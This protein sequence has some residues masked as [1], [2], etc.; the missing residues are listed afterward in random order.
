MD[1][2]PGLHF[3]MALLLALAFIA[4]CK[5]QAQNGDNAIAQHGDNAI[6]RDGLWICF[7]P[8]STVSLDSKLAET[9]RSGIKLTRTVIEQLVQ[10]NGNCKRLDA[11]N[12]KPVGFS[13][14]ASY[15]IV[16]VSDGKQ[17]GWT[18]LDMY[19]AYMQFHVVRKP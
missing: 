16:R 12:I 7:T 6:M 9:S 10:Q 1:I 14:E 11:D 2:R 18:P 8:A 5:V 4:G 19:V 15:S 3:S 13:P 17:E